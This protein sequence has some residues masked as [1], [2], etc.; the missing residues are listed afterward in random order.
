MELKLLEAN[1]T[2]KTSGGSR[3]VLVPVGLFVDTDTGVEYFVMNGGN[4]GAI[5]PRIDK[6]GK[7][8]ICKENK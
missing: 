3:I 5:C 8:V 6:D 7:P 2:D 1:V 4:G